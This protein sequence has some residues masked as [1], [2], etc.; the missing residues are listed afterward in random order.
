[1]IYNR[2]NVDTNG[3]NSLMMDNMQ[4]SNLQK[5][6]TDGKNDASI[7]QSVDRA[8]TLLV[9]ISE[10]STPMLIGEI[11]EKA[12]MNRTTAWR[13]LLTLEYRGFIE[14]DPI[15][16][17]YQLGYTVSQLSNGVD[18]YA[19]LIRRA[20]TSMERLRDLTQETVLLSVPKHSNT[21]TI[22]QIDPQQSVRLVDYVDAIL[23]L[24][25]TSNGK[26]Y[27]S[28]LPNS[29]LEILLQHPLERC[30]PKSIADPDKL[31]A[32]IEL[33]HRRG[34]GIAL[35]ELDESENGI[36]AA[37]TDKKNNL[38]AFVSVCG[39]NFRFTEEKVLSIAPTVIATAR[40]IAQ[41]L[42]A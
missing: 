35:G 6:Q 39:P 27:L 18:K 2:N 26:I 36:S 28:Y 15:T 1:M 42:E 40:E 23:P 13:L 7:V 33:T 19:P 5:D 22:D 29:E 9:L 24:H 20:R 34:F 31:R 30:T 10:S 21:L 38:I 14:R 3:A 17:G 12:K 11:V 37:I 32:E 16:K 41:N 8:L 4:K 25:C